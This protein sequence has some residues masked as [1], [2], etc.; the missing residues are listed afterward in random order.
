MLDGCLTPVSLLSLLLLLLNPVSNSSIKARRLRASFTTTLLAG[1]LSPTVVG[2]F[3]SCK[4]CFNFSPNSFTA[5]SAC[6]IPACNASPSFSSL[7]WVG[8]VS[9]A[10]KHP[11]A[12]T[13]K[14][15]TALTTNQI[16][17]LS[18]YF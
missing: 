11:L 12:R 10:T 6:L 3:K 2:I 16:F 4:A 5:A 1:A 9:S 18:V 7:F 15:Q 13:N 8:V 14:P 17:G